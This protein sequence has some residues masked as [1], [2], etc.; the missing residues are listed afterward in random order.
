[1]TFVT[2]PIKKT[3]YFCYVKL[4]ITIIL[5]FIILGNSLKVSFTYGWYALDID[6]F[7]EQFCENKDKPQLQCNGKC[8]LTKVSKD[9]SNNKNDNLPAIE[10]QKLVYCHMEENIEIAKVSLDFK[11][12][13]F[14]YTN[15]YYKLDTSSIFHPPRYS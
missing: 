15:Q 9:S 6:S 5:T 12:A 7:V 10:W 11:S 8:Y 1:M 2:L 3:Q 14:W 13:N 4:F